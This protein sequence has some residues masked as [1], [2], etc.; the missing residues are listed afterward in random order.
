MN[1]VANDERAIKTILESERL[2]AKESMKA[3][4]AAR[5]AREEKAADGDAHLEGARYGSLYRAPRL[6]KQPR[7]AR[8]LLKALVQIGPGVLTKPARVALPS[9]HPAVHICSS[10]GEYGP[11]STFR[12]K[13]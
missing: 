5:K 13:T 8:S 9:V 7:V 10:P 4:A 12:L 11:S 3:A 1:A 2:R 6:T